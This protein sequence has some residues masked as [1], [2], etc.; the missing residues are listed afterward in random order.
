M[1]RE[2][3]RLDDNVPFRDCSF[4]SYFDDRFSADQY[5]VLL[6]HI[7]VGQDQYIPDM[8]WRLPFICTE[9]KTR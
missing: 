8:H 5:I 9:E 1:T 3:S 6:D 7:I 2:Y 4:L